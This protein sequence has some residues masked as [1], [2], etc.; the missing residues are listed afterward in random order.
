MWSAIFIT[1]TAGLSLGDLGLNPPGN[2]SP[3]SAPAKTAPAAAAP[4]LLTPPA[5]PA[6]IPADLPVHSTPARRTPAE[7][8][9]R[10]ALPPAAEP[11]PPTSPSASAAPLPEPIVTRQTMFF[12]PFRVEEEKDAAR[13][14]EEVQLFVSHDRGAHWN[15]YA[16]APASRRQIPFK[17]ATDAEYWFALQTR[18]RSG[19]LRPEQITV[20]GLRVVV[21]TQPP[22]VD[23]TAK[24]DPAGQITIEWTLTDPHLQP[25]G[26]TLQGRNSADGPWQTIT[27]SP[28]NAQVRFMGATESGR[29]TWWPPPGGTELQLRAEASDAAG[30]KAVEHAQIHLDSNHGTG[31]AANPASKG[32]NP[33]FASQKSGQS[34]NPADGVLPGAINPPIGNRYSSSEAA[35]IDSSFSY[36]PPG[37]RVRMVNTRLFELDYDVEAVGPSGIGRVELWGTRN[38]GR[39]WQSFGVDNDTRSPLSVDVDGEGLYGFRIVLTNGVGLSTGPP[40]TGELPAVWIGVDTTKPIARLLGAELGAGTNDGKLIITWKAEDTMPAARPITLSFSPQPGGP[41]TPIAAGLE[42]TGRYA[43]ILDSRL[44]PQVYLRLEVRDEAGNLTVVDHPDPVPLDRSRPTAK[45]LDVR[46]KTGN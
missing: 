43:W 14:P 1:C 25:E 7:P 15:S 30:N 5:P 17:T 2:A 22:R 44:P 46:P 41:W 8:T 16:K 33:I 26:L 6:G 3:L 13:Q 32:D 42:N 40:Q 4:K 10:T 45:I 36:L 23:L 27:L 34:P 35:P 20:P 38:G 18:D 28:Q 21:D 19:R 29:V 11:L 37:E 9:A 31:T 24:A 39:T 12:I